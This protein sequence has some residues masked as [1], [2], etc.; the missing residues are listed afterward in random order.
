MP[1]MDGW[2]AATPGTARTGPSSEAG[3]GGRAAVTPPPVAVALRTTALVPDVAAANSWL[4]FAVERV[5]ERERAGQEG[6]A[7]PDRGQHAG[8]PPFP[9]PHLLGRDRQHHNPS[10]PSAASPSSTDAV[11]GWPSRPETRPSARNSTSSDRAAADGSWVTMTMVWPRSLTA[12]R[13]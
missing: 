4:K 1:V 12:V 10:L 7:E 11:P 6:H 8:Q 3:M 9:R 2:A 5:A 13:R